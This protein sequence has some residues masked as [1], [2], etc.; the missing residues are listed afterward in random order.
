[1]SG[2]TLK[3]YESRM[4]ELAQQL[5]AAKKKLDGLLEAIESN[6]GEEDEDGSIEI[7]GA[8]DADLIYED[9]VE[10]RALLK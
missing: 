3:F 7:D 5:S 2:D 8:I 10:L 9:L 4:L 6:W 1:M